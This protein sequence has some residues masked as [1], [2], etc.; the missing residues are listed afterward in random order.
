M[1]V[2]VLPAA[3]GG[4]H[5][6]DTG[7]HQAKLDYWS[8]MIPLQAQCIMAYNSIQKQQQLADAYSTRRHPSV[9]T[10]NLAQRATAQVLVHKEELKV[11][12]HALAAV[13]PES[14]ISIHIPS[15]DTSS[16]HD[17]VASLEAQVTQ[18]VERAEHHNRWLGL[19]EE[20]TTRIEKA[21][22][23]I[24][25]EQT[26]L[27]KS[28]R[29]LEGRVS[30]LSSPARV[31]G[32]PS[33]LDPRVP[34]SA[35]LATEKRIDSVDARTKDFATKATNL[36]Q[37]LKA[38]EDAQ[39]KA[40]DVNARIQTLAGELKVVQ[41]EAHDTRAKVDPLLPLSTKTDSLLSSV[42]ANQR[43][44]QELEDVKRGNSTMKAQID[45]VADMCKSTAKKVEDLRNDEIA[46]L[47]ALKADVTGLLPLKDHIPALEKFSDA[48]DTLDT[49]KSTLTGLA[50]LN[51]YVGVLK[52]LAAQSVSLIS[53]ISQQEQTA[54]TL[55][56]LE[57]DVSSC[58][59]NVYES[60]TSSKAL[61]TRVKVVEEW[62]PVVDQ[63]KEVAEEQ[64]RLKTILDQ[65]TRINADARNRNARDLETVKAG[66]RK[67]EAEHESN[68]DAV[69]SVGS[70][71]S[72]VGQANATS[73]SIRTEIAEIN[74]QIAQLKVGALGTTEKANSGME[75]IK[76]EMKNM[77]DQIN[78]LGAHVPALVALSGRS[79][80]LVKLPE[81]LTQLSTETQE[82]VRQN[83]VDCKA[84]SAVIF[85]QYSQSHEKLRKSVDE[86]QEKSRVE[87]KRIEQVEAQALQIQK[88]TKSALE[89]VEQTRLSSKAS[90]YKSLE[91]LQTRV[92][93]E[94]Q[95]TQQL[96]T[97]IS[98]LQQDSTTALQ[99]R[100]KL[101]ASMKALKTSV[102]VIETRVDPYEPLK[103]HVD[104]LAS[105][106]DKHVQINLLARNLKQ[107]QASSGHVENVFLACHATQ[108]KMESLRTSVERL[109][110]QTDPTST[111]EALAAELSSLRPLAD[112]I[113]K[114]EEQTT[115]SSGQHVLLQETIDKFQEKVSKW[116]SD[117][118]V[119]HGKIT[120]ST[121]SLR[122]EIFEV[123]TKAED[124]LRVA[125]ETA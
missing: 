117:H 120:S 47:L 60:Q 50:P 84:E 34:F 81:R 73:R 1:P 11:A 46:P 90:I 31:P 63:Q 45:V 124:A 78:P 89:S 113:A 13:T 37:R 110:Q 71:C 100:T 56:Q 87:T 36:D 25:D 97:R 82:S 106:A 58:M 27:V 30:Q 112:R 121:K 111:V 8:A 9:E 77:Q 74:N 114:V 107:A 91:E 118:K 19:V 105:I 29:H 14:V 101:Q 76:Q 26:R 109:N 64:T 39:R 61:E 99:A 12:L 43:L 48:L 3:P 57:S 96:E 94:K 5:P 104:A 69:A 92:A 38:V 68:K 80:L 44:N 17:R 53:L 66:L 95:R 88:E 41:R 125:N 102:D 23:S 49:I 33:Q 93:A 52:R 40:P 59:N 16:V 116:E 2:A 62:R 24:E 119:L 79:T 6:H 18:V 21:N 51:D 85:K 54:R 7:N 103:N 4:P 42:A 55:Q 115:A 108:V 75:Q 70:L 72:Q 86:L 15:P 67:L 35:H 22:K 65:T 28:N 123:K 83:L 32:N 10:A 122:T 20:S 98:E